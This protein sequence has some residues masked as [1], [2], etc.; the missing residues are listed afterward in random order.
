M[1]S[2]YMVA[3]GKLARTGLWIK[4]VKEKTSQHENQ[5]QKNHGNSKSLKQILVKESLL[6]FILHENQEIST[7]QNVKVSAYELVYTNLRKMYF[8]I[9]PNGQ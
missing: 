5:E 4:S 9:S 2:G 8:T 3:L 1:M 6:A 7:N